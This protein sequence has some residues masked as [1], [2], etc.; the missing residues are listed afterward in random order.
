MHPAGSQAWASRASQQGRKKRP[1]VAG[2]GEKGKPQPKEVWEGGE[3][4][5]RVGCRSSL[6]PQRVRGFRRVVTGQAGS[7]WPPGITGQAPMAEAGGEG[8]GP[9]HPWQWPDPGGG[10]ARVHCPPAV[11]GGPAG[12]GAVPD[13]AARAPE[14]AELWSR[15]AVRVCGWRRGTPR[16]E[17]GWGWQGL[18][19]PQSSAGCPRAGEAR[20]QHVAPEWLSG[21]VRPGPGWSAGGYSAPGRRSRRAQCPVSQTGK[22]RHVRSGVST[23]T[24]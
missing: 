7:W 16:A 10:G 4:R 14:R 13:K 9:G 3:G 18:L 11:S 19:G 24:R 5:G 22:P 1:D 2:P 21:A 23:A 6:C 8:V 17:A 12:V 20:S 15:R